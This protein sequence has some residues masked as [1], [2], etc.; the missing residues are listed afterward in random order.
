[1]LLDLTT[2]WLL[3]LWRKKSF[4]RCN[5]YSKLSFWISWSWNE[6]CTKKKIILQ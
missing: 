2:Y 6:V 5:A 3:D 4:W 1:M